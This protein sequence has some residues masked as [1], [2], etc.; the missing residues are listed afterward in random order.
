MAVIDSTR[1]ARDDFRW[2]VYTTRGTRLF[3]LDFDNE[4]LSVS[5]ALDDGLGF[6]STGIAFTND[7]VYALR[8]T[9]DFSR[10]TWAATLNA[11]NLVMRAPLTTTGQAL[12]L[13]DVDAV[14]AIRNPGDAGDNFMLFDDYGVTAEPTPFDQP[15]TL[16]RLSLLTA[17]GSALAASGQPHRHYA[18]EATPDLRQWTP[19][20]TNAAAADGTVHFTDPG[21]S[22]APQRFY[23]VRLVY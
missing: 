5:Y 9:M 22:G 21:T 1:A 10:N 11:T 2:S 13:G 6:F 14:W 8:V 15:P 4:S 19:L 12:S 23:R 16:E 20:T 3:T 18:L 17:G 7:V